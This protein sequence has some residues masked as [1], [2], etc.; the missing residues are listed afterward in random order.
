MKGL[1]NMSI[2]R[3]GTTHFAFWRAY[4]DFMGACYALHNAV[5]YK[6]G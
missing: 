3:E 4:I 2:E 5:I 1:D 6:N